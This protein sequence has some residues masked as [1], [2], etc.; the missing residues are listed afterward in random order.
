MD[1]VL[2]ILAGSYQEY[3]H[4]VRARH[5]ELRD[6]QPLYYC[7]ARDVMGRRGAD[8]IEIGTFSRRRDAGK[9]RELCKRYLTK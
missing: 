5:E 7:N 2:I 6:I 8:W 3:K 4:Y 1:T 9:I